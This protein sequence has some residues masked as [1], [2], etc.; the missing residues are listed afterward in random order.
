MGD[1]TR[2]LDTIAEQRRVLGRRLATFRQAAE[3]TQAQ[4]AIEMTYDR[5]TVA[6]VERGR[7]GADIRFW[8][9]ADVACRADGALL[10]AFHEFE[11]SKAEYERQIRDR[12]LSE[13]RAKTARMRGQGGPPSDPQDRRADMTGPSP[14]LDG[15]RRVVLGHRID[16]ATSTP[17]DEQT[18]RAGMLEAHR[19]Y[20]LADYDGAARVL[21]PLVR[22]LDQGNGHAERFTGITAAVYIAAAK[23]ATKQ[24]D[25]GLAWVTADRALRSAS[26][27]NHVPLVG[28]ARYQVACALQRAGHENDA[29]QVAV[30][31]ATDIAGHIDSPSG[32]D[33][34]REALSVRGALL[35][36]AAILAA[37][38][39]HSGDA[40]RHLGVARQLA[41][42]L[43]VDGNWLWTAFGPTNVAIHEVAVHVDL[44]ETK[45]AI[46][47]GEIIDTD[48]LPE[49]LLGRRSQVHLD[50][51]RAAAQLY[52]DQLAVLHLLEAERVAA[53][54]IS[55]N[56]TARSLLVELL[57]RERKGATP[58]LRAL[59]SR[60][61][62]LR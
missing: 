51:A 21:P 43:A 27:S 22:Q 57:A 25:A 60:A 50:L 14:N 20:Q 55:R 19:L 32:R 53:Q 40:L 31:A 13:A 37:R 44:G 15:L 9:A 52:D 49:V 48:G 61:E 10:N 59:A 62:V 35:L 12:E 54:A 5:S 46:Q 45:R 38:R 7:G 29:E 36:L 34:S 17:L 18:A 24:A 23:L 16:S 47:F 4:L 39:G 8:Q 58:G 26:E 56:A 33:R 41:A 2:E 1:V 28:A 3:L 42:E 6:H 11:T 30:D